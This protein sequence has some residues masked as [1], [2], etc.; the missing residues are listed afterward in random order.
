MKK[1]LFVI[2]KMGGGGAERVVSLL[3]NGFSKDNS[4]QIHTFVGGESFYALNGNITLSSCGIK[5]ITKGIFRKFNIL[6]ELPKTFFRT[7]KLIKKGGF[8]IVIPF[9]AEADIITYFCRK[10]GVKFKYVCSE[11]NDPT[12]KNKLKMFFLKKAYR[13]A[14][15]LVL[16][17]E[18][19][20]DFYSSVKEEK[21]IVIPNPVNPDNLPK[22]ESVLDKTVIAVGR[23]D[24]QKNFDMLINAFK[25]VTT[26]FPDYNLKIYGEGTERTNLENLIDKLEL[27]DSVK[28]CG[29]SKDV[30]KEVA[31]AELFVMSSNFE[32]F[33]NALLES[34]AI[35]LPVISTDFFSGTAR[36]LIDDN[37]GILVPVGDIDKLKKAIIEMLGNPNK[38]Q[39][40]EYNKEKV[41]PY[42]D[43]KILSRWETEVI[44]R[45]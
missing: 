12:K 4:V 19:V 33:P 2:P 18:K 10:T 15:L 36:E 11:R 20:K 27:N 6:F 34:M 25:G 35:G 24:V 9:L 5:K 42:Y 39:L 30:L 23:L 28:L 29:A 40:G 22:R 45:V 44:N 37:G 1:I 8:D 31:K 32:G 7:R 43:D 16:Q 41:K 14:N 38:T 13:K 17:S 3:A 26:E 21:K